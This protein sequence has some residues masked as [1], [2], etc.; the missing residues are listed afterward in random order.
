MNINICNDCKHKSEEEIYNYQE[1]IRCKNNPFVIDDRFD[2]KEIEIRPEKAGELWATGSVN[3]MTQK[4]G[5]ELRMIPRSYDMDVLEEIDH[6]RHGVGCYK[7]LYPP[8][9][10]DSV[11]RLE[12]E[13]VVCKEDSDCVYTIETTFTSHKNLVNKPMKMILI[14]KEGL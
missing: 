7:R 2:A 8:V 3:Y 10:D 6:F 13:G 4:I 14:P 11:E 12:I 9:E 5:D 1:C